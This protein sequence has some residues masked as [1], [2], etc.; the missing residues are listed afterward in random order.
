MSIQIDG[1]PVTACQEEVAASLAFIQ[2]LTP[3]QQQTAIISTRKADEDMKAGA[4]ADIVIDSRAR[5]YFR[6]PTYGVG[7]KTSH[8]CGSRVEVG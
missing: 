8:N 5:R 2:S 6:P 1:Q 4:S 7:A 3:A